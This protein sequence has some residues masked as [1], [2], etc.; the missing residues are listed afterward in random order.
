MRVLAARFRDRRAAA[1]VRD[2]LI[3]RRRDGAAPLDIAPL[4]VPG[5]PESSD[6]VLAGQFADDEAAAVTELV[7]Q[8]G[9]EIVANVDETWTR[10]RVVAHPTTWGSNL[11]RARVHA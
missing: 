7:R 10:P 8:G 1:A 4:G 2:R 6:M 11:N 3:Q 5:N 9:G